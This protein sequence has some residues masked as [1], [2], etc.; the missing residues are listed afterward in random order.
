VDGV[1]R[2]SE[3]RSQAVDQLVA[4]VSSVP[5][6][7]DVVNNHLRRIAGSLDIIAEG[8][9]MT[10]VVFPDADVKIFL[11]AS[12]DSRAERRFGELGGA[13]PL[14]EI[15]QQIAERDEID[16]TKPVGNLKLAPGALYIDSSHLTLDQVCDMVLRAILSLNHTSGEI[17][18]S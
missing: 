14:K 1:P 4:R 5:G 17:G 11:D 13:V 12:L 16:R 7:R 10:T 18:Q 8:R 6:V 2:T 9:D 3:L 15:R